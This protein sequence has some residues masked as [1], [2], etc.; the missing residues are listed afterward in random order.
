[1]KGCIDAGVDASS[2]HAE[3]NEKGHVDINDHPPEKAQVQDAL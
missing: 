2:D 3:M 1:M